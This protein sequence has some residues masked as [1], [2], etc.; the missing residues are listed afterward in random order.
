[1]VEYLVITCIREE[2]TWQ[3]QNVGGEITTFKEKTKSW[4]WPRAQHQ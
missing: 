1:M 3:G 2:G 4:E